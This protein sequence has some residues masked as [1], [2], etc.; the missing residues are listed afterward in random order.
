MRMMIAAFL[1]ATVASPTLAT[2]ANSEQGQVMVRTGDLDL[3]T[4][5]GQRRLDQR[6]DVA[7]IRLCGSPI[8]FSRDE[9][10]ALDACRADA[11]TAAA[12]HIKAARARLAVTVASQR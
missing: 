9:L 7:L 3:A 2:P 12:P 10:A 11:L 8:I 5:A 1:A 6:I 4:A